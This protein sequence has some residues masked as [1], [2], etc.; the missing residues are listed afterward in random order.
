MQTMD[1]IEILRARVDAASDYETHAEALYQLGSYFYEAD[2]L[3]FYNPEAW[4]G[5]RGAR[6]IWFGAAGL[7]TPGEAEAIWRHSTT[8]EPVAHA[9][10]TFLDVADRF[11]GTKAGRDALASAVFADERLAGYNEYWREAYAIGRYAGN[12]RPTYAEVRT[13]YPKY[14]WPLGNG[15]S[16]EPSTRTVDGKPAWPPKPKPVPPKPLWRRAVDRGLPLLW[17]AYAWTYGA[18][19]G[20]VVRVIAYHVGQARLGLLFAVLLASAYAG[21]RSWASA[22]PLVGRRPSRTAAWLVARAARDGVSGAG[23]LMR[24]TRDDGWLAVARGSLLRAD[25]PGNEPRADREERLWDWLGRVRW[26]ALNTR[27]GL[28]LLAYALPASLLAV[29]LLALASRL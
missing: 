4:R 28:A 29:L 10:R 14:A 18:V 15:T 3:R 13:R 22:L 20:F 25:E 26:V 19:T 6:L 5:N 24:H 2:T 11:P 8:H 21:F 23:E 17:S 12:R 27:T 9:L 7:R 16:W 1:D